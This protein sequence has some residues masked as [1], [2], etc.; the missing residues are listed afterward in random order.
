MG[1]VTF[2]QRDMAHSTRRLNKIGNVF[3]K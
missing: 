1:V 2:G 3:V